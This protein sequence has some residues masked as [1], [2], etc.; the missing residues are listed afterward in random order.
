M[1]KIK[2]QIFVLCA[3]FF[4]VTPIAFV[5]AELVPCG[6]T[7]EPSC[8]ICHLVGGAHAI[9]KQLLEWALAL[10]LL[11]IMAAGVMYI[12]SAGNQS[13]TT[14]A[15]T[16]IKNTLIGVSIMLLAFLI[17]TTVINNLFLNN[18]SDVPVSAGGLNIVNNAWNFNSTC[19]SSNSNAGAV[20]G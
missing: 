16:A 7:G 15:K 3:M 20:G 18:N 13:T 2:K 10:S 9:V 8:T 1:Q 6:N 12:T 5:D 14:M 4:L 17:V 19:T 11:V